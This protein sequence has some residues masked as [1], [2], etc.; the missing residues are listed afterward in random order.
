M[1]LL[2]QRVLGTAILILLAVLVFVKQRATGSI[3]VFDRRTRVWI[4]LTNLF[5]LFFLLVV[6]PV[7]GILLIFEQ[8]DAVDPTMVVSIP[9][10]ILAGLEI[11]GLILY[12]IGLGLMAW[13]LVSLGS[14]YQ[15][16]GS[17]PPQS[18]RFVQSGPYQSIRHPMYS[19]VLIIALGLALLTQ[20]MLVFL[21]FCV[22]VV[23]IVRLIP[24]EESELPSAYRERYAAYQK[25]IKRLIPYVY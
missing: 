17:L 19:A 7:V 1:H 24:I 20:S 15:L 2:T 11:A 18:D 5:N 23:L 4:W 6:N 8:L 14:F 22:Y 9:P 10:R 21:V 16:G 12:T 25:N 13:A 3:I